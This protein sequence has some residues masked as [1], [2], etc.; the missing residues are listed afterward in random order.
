MDGG[1]KLVR[2]GFEKRFGKE[3]DGVEEIRYFSSSR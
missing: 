2:C 3:E 1:R